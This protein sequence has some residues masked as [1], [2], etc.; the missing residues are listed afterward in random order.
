MI[1]IISPVRSGA[2]NDFPF[3]DLN[4]GQATYR[5]NYF[6]LYARYNTYHDVFELAKR[7]HRLRH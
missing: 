1:A 7:I 3:P 2:L 4:C 6:S 5:T